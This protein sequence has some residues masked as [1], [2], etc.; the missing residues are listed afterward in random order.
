MLEE[1]SCALLAPVA[2]CRL[3]SSSLFVN[4]K[5]VHSSLLRNGTGRSSNARRAF[6][7]SSRTR[8]ALSAAVVV[9][10]R[11]RKACSLI[12]PPKRHR[13]LLR[14]SKSILVLF[15]HPSRLVGCRRRHSS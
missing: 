13:A 11:E 3:P 15:S 7:C 2:P 12:T 10:L 14:C 8:R 9:T 4:E 1:H 6:L 5:R